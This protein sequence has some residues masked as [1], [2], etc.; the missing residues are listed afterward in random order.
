[1]DTQL[2]IFIVEDNDDLREA[3]VEAL[4]CN[5]HVVQSAECAETMDEQ[6]GAFP[7][8]VV[9]LDLNLPGEDGMSIARRLRKVNAKLGIIMLTARNKNQDIVSGY[10]S[11]AD[12]YLTK[13]T[14][15]EMLEAAIQALAR[16]VRTCVPQ[17]VKL[18]LNPMSRQLHGPTDSVSLSHLESVLLASLVQ[19][20]DH[21]LEYWQLMELSGRL[22][23]K[24]ALE[25]HMVRLRKKLEQVG[26]GE[27]TDRVTIKAIRGRGY[28]LCVGIEI[29]REMVG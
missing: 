20:H 2:N 7:A 19:A 24:A 5:G 16:R 3:M 21:Y 15:L 11:G 6:L 25:L 4:Q 23:E 13:P 22:L 29:R 10:H 28:Q 8:E 26:V 9:V 27:G 12:I 18:S 1:M 14:T 17:A